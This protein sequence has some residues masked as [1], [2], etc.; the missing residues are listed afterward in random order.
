MIGV[1]LTIILVIV[2][3]FDSQKT[4]D[5][6]TTDCTML[7][8]GTGAVLVFVHHIA[9]ITDGGVLNHMNFPS[10]AI[11]FLLAGYGLMYGVMNKEGYAKKIVFEKI[12]VIIVWSLFSALCALVFNIFIGEPLSLR[13]ILLCFTGNRILNWFF[14]ALIIHYLIFATATS[15]CKGNYKKLLLSLF[16]L[17]LLYMVACRVLIQKTSWYASSLAFPTGAAIAYLYLTKKRVFNRG[18]DRGCLLLLGSIFLITFA[19]VFFDG[20]TLID[21]VFRLICQLTSAEIFAVLC[22]FLCV[23]RKSKGFLA[24]CGKNSAQFLFMQ[25]ISL[26]ALR[27]KRIYIDNNMLFIF[28]VVILQFAL[29]CAS[30][31]TYDWLK[32]KTIK[33]VR[34]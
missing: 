12:P 1:V 26:Y 34:R 33:I 19:C 30:E 11:F 21:R 2:F 20:N 7:L 25:N 16:T 5:R 6:I 29:V 9:G 18:G 27:N 10:V 24:W 15:F 31:S 28:G 4:E 22:L 8:K 23:G 32:T 3:L 17:T 13:D 14:A